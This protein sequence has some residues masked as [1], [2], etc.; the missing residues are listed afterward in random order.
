VN[1]SAQV[2]PLLDAGI[3]NLITDDPARMRQRLDEILALDAPERLLLR[4]AHGI[5]R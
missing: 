2:G 5:G 3:A 1:D 4:T